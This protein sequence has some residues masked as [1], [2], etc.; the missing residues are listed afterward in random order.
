LEAATD[1]AGSIALSIA[2]VFSFSLS[3]FHRTMSDF[4]D[5]LRRQ[6]LLAD[7]AAFAA[8]S[9]DGSTTGGGVT[10]E[11]L[12]E[13]LDQEALERQVR[14]Q[15]CIHCFSLRLLRPRELLYVF[16]VLE[17]GRLHASSKTV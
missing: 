10:L 7:L 14:K 11:C 12:M 17:R 5:E 6:G 3:S 16:I 9:V 8:S 13:R 15:S 2:E 1:Q 4:E